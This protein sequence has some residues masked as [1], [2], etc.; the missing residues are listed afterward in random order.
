MLE[1]LAWPMPKRARVIKVRIMGSI[2][3]RG[4]GQLLGCNCV[5]LLGQAEVVVSCGL[6]SACVSGKKCQLK[7]HALPNCFDVGRWLC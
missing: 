2:L 6:L 7:S 1:G 3:A 4:S 5:V